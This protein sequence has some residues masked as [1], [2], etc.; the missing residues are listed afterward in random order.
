MASQLFIDLYHCDLSI[1]DDMEKI[2]SVARAAIQ[3]IHAEIVEECCHRFQPCG[4]TYIAVITTSHFS[5]HTWPEY[6]YAAIDIFSC[7]ED[8]PDKIAEM[9]KNAFRASKCTTR[10]FRRNIRGDEF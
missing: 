9:L 10:Q 8:V 3:N 6:G 4:I 7:S 5:V 2:K 1:I